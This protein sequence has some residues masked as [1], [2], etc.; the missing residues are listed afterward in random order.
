[1]NN[2]PSTHYRPIPPAAPVIKNPRGNYCLLGLNKGATG[3]ENYWNTPAM[4][5]LTV[6]TTFKDCNPS[7]GVYTFDFLQTQ[8]AL[9]RAHGK[10]FGFYVGALNRTNECPDYVKGA[11]VDTG[12]KNGLVAVPW[13]PIFLAA[14]IAF[15]GELGKALGD[16]DY[17][18]MGALGATGESLLSADV[19]GI[20]AFEAA[21]GT[22]KWVGS[23]TQIGD[24]YAAAAPCWT[25][26]FSTENPYGTD[27]TLATTKT[28]AQ[29]LND[30]VVP[31]LLKYPKRAGVKNSSGSANTHDAGQPCQLI[32]DYSATNPVGIQ[33]INSAAGTLPKAPPL[34]G[35]LATTMALTKYGAL[36]AAQ[37]AWIKLGCKFD[38]IYEVDFLDEANWPILIANGTALK[39]VN[40]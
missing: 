31:M 10:A 9:A 34:G 33:A 25:F 28:G 20:A 5:G 23:C 13:D 7:V 35:T 26:I 11:S 27:E 12:G 15:I 38:E 39:A 19:A 14:W 16:A 29:A 8:L 18:V 17:T 37:Q 40:P 6:R 2:Q 32:H 1:M 21:G 36:D 3:S 22:T 30:A 4:D 24:A